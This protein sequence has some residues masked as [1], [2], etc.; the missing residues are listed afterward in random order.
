MPYPANRFARLSCTAFIFYP[1]VFLPSLPPLRTL[2]SLHT[3]VCFHLLPP[4]P[5]RSHIPRV[6]T[7]ISG[8]QYS[9]RYD[10]F[11]IFSARWKGRRELLQPSSF[12]FPSSCWLPRS[13]NSNRCSRLCQYEVARDHGPLIEPA[14]NAS[15]RMKDGEK[16]PPS[17]QIFTAESG[18]N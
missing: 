9:H 17:R 13:G 3:P 5:P 10:V 18:W 1:P 7:S 11:V 12:P 4:P 16:R 15:L 14:R 6:N 2:H 8:Y